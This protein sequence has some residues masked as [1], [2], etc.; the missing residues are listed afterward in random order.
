MTEDNTMTTDQEYFLTIKHRIVGIK[1]QVD[2]PKCHVTEESGQHEIAR[3]AVAMVDVRS[4]LTDAEVAACEK[5]MKDWADE[6]SKNH[7]VA[8]KNI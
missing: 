8:G 3:L 2:D 1:A 7:L 5:H 4:R 6:C